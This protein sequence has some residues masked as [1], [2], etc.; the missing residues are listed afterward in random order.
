MI[1]GLIHDKWFPL[2]RICEDGDALLIPFDSQT[3]FN[4]RC[5]TFD[6]LLRIEHLLSWAVVD[7]ERIEIYDFFG[8]SFDKSRNQIRVE[9]NIPLTLTADVREFAI[10]VET[11]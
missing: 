11:P 3:S 5:V 8:L 10:D 7:T 4:S 9:A 2:N 1:N 6:S